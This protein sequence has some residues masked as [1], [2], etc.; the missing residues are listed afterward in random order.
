MPHA[1]R[2][3]LH[4]VW[5]FFAIL[6]T[7]LLLSLFRPLSASAQDHSMHDM[8]AGMS[9]SVDEGQDPALQ[10]RLFAD[11]R[12][13]EFNHHLAGF[14]VVLA[15]V[16][17]LAEGSFRERWPWVRYAWPVCFILSGLFVLVWSDTE[18]WPF[19]TQSWYYGL[20]HHAEVLQHKV[21][22]LLLLAVGGVEFRRARKGVKSAWDGWV[23]PVIAM[24]G[25]TMFFF[26]DHQAG[27]HAPNHMELMQRI[28]SQHF[29]FAVAGFGIGL[30]KGMAETKTAWQTFFA[31]LFP[32]LLMV[33][34]ALLLVYAE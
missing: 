11:K 24:I 17:I 4:F 29:S 12:E 19:G 3:S 6:P 2:Y 16:F 32:A 30:S 31:R 9:M 15:G 28:Q 8:H 21:F 14:F 1:Q 18:L 20:T 5:M 22:A 25:S 7:A 26:H 13:S 34:G 33:L 23:F 27:M 10:A